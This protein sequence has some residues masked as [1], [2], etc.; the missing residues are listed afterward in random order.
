M[1][2]ITYSNNISDFSPE[3]LRGFFVGWRSPI[4]SDRHFQ[5]LK[6]S[7]RFFIAM[8]EDRV[9]GFVNCISDELHFAFIPMIEVLP[10][11]QSKGIGTELM[12]RLLEEL[13][14]LQCI[15]LTCDADVQPFYEKLGMLKSNGM[16]IRNY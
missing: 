12:K 4:S 2:M 11:Y 15:D 6:N 5:I 16:I 10:E 8:D 7:Y 9:V 14:N 13:R 1:A 3:N